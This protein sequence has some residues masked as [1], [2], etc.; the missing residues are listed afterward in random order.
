MCSCMVSCD[1]K[2]VLLIN[3]DTYCLTCGYRTLNN[4][5]SM[6]IFALGILIDRDDLCFKAVSEDLTFIVDLTT[7][8]SVKDCLV[9][10]YDDVVTFFGTVN[11]T[12]LAVIVRLQNVDDLCITLKVIV[13]VVFRGI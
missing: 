8:R 10:N 5:K 1:R 13:T 12:E 4:L 7:H 9:S 11:D 6:E 2:S 3:F